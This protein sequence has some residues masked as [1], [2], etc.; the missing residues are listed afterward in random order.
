MNVSDP[1]ATPVQLSSAF[2]ALFMTSKVM[3]RFVGSY[4]CF[5]LSD[6]RNKL[7]VVYAHD[8]GAASRYPTQAELCRAFPLHNRERVTY[9]GPHQLPVPYNEIGAIRLV[10]MVIYQQDR[11]RILLLLPDRVPTELQRRSQLLLLQWSRP[12]PL[13][14]ST[15]M[16]TIGQERVHVIEKNALE[17]RILV[18]LRCDERLQLFDQGLHFNGGDFNIPRL[19][20]LHCESRTA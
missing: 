14:V 10:Q 13:H 15:L 12:N 1:A 5:G 8:T 9:T 2:W 16:E 6:T 18:E 4:I 7:L 3:V 17:T 19:L 20:P 11:R